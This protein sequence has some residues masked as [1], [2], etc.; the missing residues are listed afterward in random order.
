VVDG[1]R[2]L[3]DGQIPVARARG[4]LPLLERTRR[5]AR[6]RDEGERKQHGDFAHYSP[7]RIGIVCTP[8]P[9]RYDIVT[10]SPPIFSSLYCPS[11]VCPSVAHT[12]F[13]LPSE[14]IAYFFSPGGCTT[15]MNLIVIGG[16]GGG[17]YPGCPGPGGGGGG[18]T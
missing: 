7:P 5:R 10:D 11:T 17:T 6:G 4:G 9:S 14:K 3:L 12:G 16:G 15:P 8:L 13:P 1:L 2:E 18:G